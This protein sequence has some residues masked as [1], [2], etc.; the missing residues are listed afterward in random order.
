M[1]G[2]GLKIVKLAQYLDHGLK[3][4]IPELDKGHRFRLRNIPYDQVKVA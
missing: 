2:H 4:L 1:Q 3:N